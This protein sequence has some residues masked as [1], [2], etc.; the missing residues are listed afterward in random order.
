VV[1]GADVS[2]RIIDAL[3]AASALVIVAGLATGVL[4]VREGL[5][6]AAPGVQLAFY[7]PRFR[8]GLTR[9]DCIAVTHLG[10]AL[11]VLF[12]VGT[13]VWARAGLPENIYLR[14]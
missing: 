1:H 9:G 12:L 8:R 11:L 2:R 5:M 14:G 6:L 13:Y 3:L 10:T 4:G 7:R